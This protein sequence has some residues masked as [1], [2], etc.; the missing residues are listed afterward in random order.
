MENVF[1][2]AAGGTG[3]HFY[4]GFALGK[5]LASRG[6]DVVFIIKRGSQIAGRERT[7]LSGN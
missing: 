5:E 7:A 4:P 1:M 2:I 3:G 6:R